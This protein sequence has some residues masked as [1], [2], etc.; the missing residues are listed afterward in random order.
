M[1]F[2]DFFFLFLRFWEP[3]FE[4][5]EQALKKAFKNGVEGAKVEKLG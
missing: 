2:F 1:S 4:I 5:S 3:I